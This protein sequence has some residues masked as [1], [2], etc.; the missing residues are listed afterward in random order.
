M[1]VKFGELADRSGLSLEVK[2]LGV[3]MVKDHTRLNKELG[4]AATSMG[5]TIE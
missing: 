4:A 1:E 5:L 2:E 3:H